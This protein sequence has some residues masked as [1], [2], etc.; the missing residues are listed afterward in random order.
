LN[1]QDEPKIENLEIDK[2]EEK[3]EELVE[4]VKGEVTIK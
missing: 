3:P 1:E 2:V 4:I